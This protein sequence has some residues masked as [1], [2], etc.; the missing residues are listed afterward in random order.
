MLD[1]HLALRDRTKQF[2]LRILKVCNSLPNSEAALASA[3]SFFARRLLLRQITGRWAE[4][5][6]RL[7]S[8]QKWVS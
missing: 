2:A 3:D 4:R 1:Q 8:L 7:N 6:P 5:S